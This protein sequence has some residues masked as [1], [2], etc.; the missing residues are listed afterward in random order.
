MHAPWITWRQRAIWRVFGTHVASPLATRP[1]AYTS[2]L[3]YT[4]TTRHPNRTVPLYRLGHHFGCNCTTISPVSS[5]ITNPSLYSCDTTALHSTIRSSNENCTPPKPASLPSPH[6]DPLLG[7]QHL[8]KARGTEERH[9][10]APSAPAW[11]SV[12]IDTRTT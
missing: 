8:E 4:L 6:L 9:C 11:T 3:S 12:Q 1:S 5:A 10:K 7:W 2:V